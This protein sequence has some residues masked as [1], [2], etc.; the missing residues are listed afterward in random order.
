MADLRYPFNQMT[1]A[2]FDALCVD[3]ILHENP[4]MRVRATSLLADPSVR[5]DAILTKE[6]PKG[7][8]SIGVESSHRTSFNF[9][10]WEAARQRVRRTQARLDEL[11]FITSAP[12]S[13]ADT[14]RILASVKDDFPKLQVIGEAGVIQMLDRHRDVAD[15]FF[16]GVKR[17]TQTRFRKGLAG[18]AVIALSMLLSAAGVGLA[19]YV[20]PTSKPTTLVAQLTNVE[21]SLEKLHGLE[22]NLKMLR[23]E[24]N[25]EADE[26]ARVKREYEQAMTLKPLTTEQLDRVKAA[27]T[28]QTPFEFWSALLGGFLGGVGSSIL[29]TVLLDEFRRRR[30]LRKV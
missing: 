12:I 21:S 15:L 16:R 23:T 22:E 26:T 14:Q 7:H 6:T 27:V 29:G 17:E 3:L 4:E 2:Q 30:A 24:I 11:I 19:L 18:V 9:A 10:T 13:E 20:S 28:R 8:I 5:I 25:K 1:S